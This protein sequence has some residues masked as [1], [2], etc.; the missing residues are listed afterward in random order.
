MCVRAARFERAMRDHIFAH[1]L[2]QNGQKL[3][4]FCP[5]N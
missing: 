2:E 1:F 5:K 3:A 4:N